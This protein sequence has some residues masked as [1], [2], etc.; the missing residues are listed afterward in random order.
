M[1]T[2]GKWLPHGALRFRPSPQLV[3]TD[4]VHAVPTQTGLLVIEPPALITYVAIW[5]ICSY[6]M[7]PNTLKVSAASDGSLTTGG[8]PSTVAP[9]P[10]IVT[11]PVALVRTPILL[12]SGAEQWVQDGGF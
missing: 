4:L 9:A 1:C 8:L 5:V 7:S 12:E 6:V 3:G 10:A 2:I 11:E